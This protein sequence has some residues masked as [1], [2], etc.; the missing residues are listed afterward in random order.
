MPFLDGD[1]VV[2][3]NIDMENMPEGMLGMMKGMMGEGNFPEDARIH[4]FSIGDLDGHDSRIHNDHE[5]RG[6]DEDFFGTLMRITGGEDF[7]RLPKGVREHVR[8]NLPEGIREHIESAM[9]SGEFP[10]GMRIRALSFGDGEGEA[11]FKMPFFGNDVDIDFDMENMRE[12]FGRSISDLEENGSIRSLPMVNI[13]KIRHRY[14]DEG[15]EDENDEWDEKDEWY[16]ENDELQDLERRIHELEL[17][18]R[19]MELELERA[20][21]ELQLAH[22]HRQL[23][24]V[25]N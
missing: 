16:E 15:E 2:D 12:R 3:I 17:E 13:Q 18:I 5:S 21:L 10:K 14:S 9:E 24:E 6:G 7:E 4:A 1:V 11:P 19:M 8:D 25:E 22:T 23:E 20:E